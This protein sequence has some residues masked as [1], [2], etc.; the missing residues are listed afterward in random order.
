MQIFLRHNLWAV[1]WHVEEEVEDD[2]AAL[3]AVSIKMAHR[4]LSTDRCIPQTFLLDSHSLPVVVS[5]Q[6]RGVGGFR[7]RPT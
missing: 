2:V 3:I 5:Q 4:T 6:R 1:W 7:R